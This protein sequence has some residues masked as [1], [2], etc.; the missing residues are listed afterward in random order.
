M[1]KRCVFLIL[2]LLYGCKAESTYVEYKVRTGAN[3]VLFLDLENRSDEE[4][5]IFYS[6]L[7]YLRVYDDTN[8]NVTISADIEDS[9]GIHNHVESG[10]RLTLSLGSLIKRKGEF[11]NGVRL[12]LDLPVY[13]CHDFESRNQQEIFVREPFSSEHMSL[14]IPHDNLKFELVQVVYSW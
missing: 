2:L 3:G 6:D 4:L 10:G 1:V 11:G 5:C 8:K 13:K 9:F 14:L 12:K 7:N